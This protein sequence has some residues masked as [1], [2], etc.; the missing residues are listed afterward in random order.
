MIETYYDPIT[1]VQ[2]YGFSFIV[3]F[4]LMVMVIRLIDWWA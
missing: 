2:L 3:P 1:L 4:A